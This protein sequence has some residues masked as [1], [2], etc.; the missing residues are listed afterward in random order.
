MK[1]VAQLDLS[2]Q[3]DLFFAKI[4]KVLQGLALEL[5][6][7]AELGTEVAHVWLGTLDSYM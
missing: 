7:A 3:L 4:I 6:E 1:V 5:L 2:H